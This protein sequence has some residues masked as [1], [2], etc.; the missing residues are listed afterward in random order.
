[1]IRHHHLTNKNQNNKKNLMKFKI[2]NSIQRMV[3]LTNFCADFFSFS[4]HIIS[5]REKKRRISST[6]SLIVKQETADD[7]FTPGCY[8]VHVHLKGLKK[9]DFNLFFCHK[10][11]L[12]K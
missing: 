3:E 9:T 5:H 11:S 1:M 2:L 4:K 10:S 6:N 7:N 8:P 12:S